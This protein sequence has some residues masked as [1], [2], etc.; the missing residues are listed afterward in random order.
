MVF[1]A[2]ENPHRLVLVGE[3]WAD[4]PRCRVG[5]AD[6]DEWQRPLS[7]NQERR[8]VFWGCVRDFPRDDERGH[9]QG[10]S[11]FFLFRHLQNHEG[12]PCVWWAT[13]S[14]PSVPSDTPEARSANSAKLRTSDFYALFTSVTLVPNRGYVEYSDLTKCIFKCIFLLIVTGFMIGCCQDLSPNDDFSPFLKDS[15]GKI[16]ILG[17]YY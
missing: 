13:L 14:P 12:S 1:A 3:A 9:G 8:L 11:E 17:L 2:N 10:R 4:T 15:S 16:Q 7:P 6:R 5:A